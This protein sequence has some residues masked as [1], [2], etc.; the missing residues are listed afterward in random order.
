VI[1]NIGKRNF[2]HSLPRFKAAR[3]YYSNYSRRT[4]LNSLI[5]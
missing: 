4:N 5:L 3:H 2:I 1:Q